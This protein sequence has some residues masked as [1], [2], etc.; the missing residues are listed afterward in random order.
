MN[1]AMHAGDRGRMAARIDRLP[2]TWVHWRL[3]LICQLLWG[4]VAAAEGIPAKLYPFV[5]GPEKAFGFGGFALLLAVQ[6]GIGILAG[7]LLSGPIA[8]CWGR[9]KALLAFLIGTALPLWPVALTD[10]YTLLVVCFGLSSVA[11]GGAL[12]T[13]IRYL[14][15]MLPRHCRDRV[16]L[17][18]QALAVVVFGV[19]GNVPAILWVPRDYPRFVV[20]FTL[21]ILCVLVPLTAWYLPES[22]VWLE[23][24]GR[25]RAAY[26][27]MV[28]L[29]EACLRYSGLSRLRPPDYTAGVASGR[30]T[31]PV[32]HLL[33]GSGGQSIIPLLIAWMLGYSGMVYGFAG[34]E[35]AILHAFGLS[36]GETFGV[37]LT[38][39]MVGDGVALAVCALMGDAV[40][41]RVTILVAALL[42][43]TAL[44]GLYFVHG[45]AS[46]YLLVTLFWGAETAWQ[47]SMY[48]YTAASFPPRLR[49]SGTALID[50]V[51]R[52]GAVF[53]PLVAGS[54]YAATASLGYYGWFAYLALPGAL[55]PAL[56]VGWSGSDQRRA[57]PKEISA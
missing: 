18:S 54:L 50:T 52:L 3:V 53:G 12:T 24:R 9:R 4:V 20:W 36:A 44:T 13:N 15:E 32:R 11:M 1:D 51:G 31:V 19:C 29:E 5:W 6:F 43:V 25:R 41:H 21:V 38:S 30:A 26:R 7:G 46:A 57:L 16:I 23:A 45:T 49:Q 8:S 56:L 17:A 10:Q 47:F 40:D 14:R 55:I 22:P 28:R 2:L 39:S 42:S 34:Y 27:V 48:R 35:P 33:R 37:I